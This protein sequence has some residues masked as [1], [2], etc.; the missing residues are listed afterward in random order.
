MPPRGPDDHSGGWSGDRL[1]ERFCCCCQCRCLSSLEGRCEGRRRATL[2]RSR[3]CCFSAPFFPPGC[4]SPISWTHRRRLPIPPVP[5]EVL[6]L[7]ARRLRGRELLLGRAAGDAPCRWGCGLGVCSAGAGGAGGGLALHAARRRG[8]VA[9]AGVDDGVVGRGHRWMRPERRERGGQ[10]F[11]ELS[12]GKPGVGPTTAW[13]GVDAG[14]PA[15]AR[16]GRVQAWDLDEVTA[17]LWP[18]PAPTVGKCPRGGAHVGATLR[19]SAHLHLH[20][21]S[22]LRGIRKQGKWALGARELMPV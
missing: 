4:F 18:H 22:G 7:A 13:P 2:R 19:R 1:L 16:A 10:E 3:S 21:R 8:Q 11:E 17:A 12:A 9:E 20:P 15:R 6:L 14:W 5:D